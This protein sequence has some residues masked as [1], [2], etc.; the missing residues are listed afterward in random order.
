M[1]SY[2][3]YNPVRKPII[4][5]NFVIA[6]SNSC[7]SFI[8]GFAVWSVV[9]YLQSLDSIAKSKTSSI[10][11]AFIAYPTAIDSMNMPNLWAIILGLTLFMLGIDSAF[12]FIEAASTVICDTTWGRNYP[13]MYVAFL[14]CTF[15]YV[16]SIPF[17]T[18]WGFILFDVVDYYMSNT[19]LILV[20]ILQCFGCGWG[21][22]AENTYRKSSN[23]ATGLLVLFFGF[24]GSISILAL[25]FVLI[26]KITIGLIVTSAVVLLVVS[27][28]SF[29]MSK[30]S[31][32]DWYNEIFMCGVRKLG[33]SMS[34]LNRDDD[35]KMKAWEPYFV[36]Y[37]GFTIKFSTP[38]ALMFIFINAI[39]RN[40]ET[41]Y[42]GYSTFFQVVGI[43]IPILGFLFFLYFVFFNVHEEPFDHSVFEE[44][45]QEIEMSKVNQVAN[46]QN[47]QAADGDKLG[48]GST[49]KGN[50]ADNATLDQNAPAPEAPPA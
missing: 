38:V 50:N 28:L 36:F 6:L 27:P 47:A 40:V 43:I 15:G 29:A 2:G 3:S 17:C 49:E 31:L 8:A 26:E 20:G 25:I 33:Y 5:D 44:G 4:L 34:M 37:F 45:L 22:D 42:G 7:L 30:M 10:G 12:S 46:G 13:R 11:L 35:G 23:H 21:F 18:N 16:L 41:P 39:K 32:K 14:L 24:W 9:G 19:L 1:T 48:I